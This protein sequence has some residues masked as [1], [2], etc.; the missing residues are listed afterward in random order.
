MLQL[1]LQD[2]VALVF[3]GDNEVGKE[4]IQLFLDAGAKV[5]YLCKSN[6]EVERS[7]ILNFKAESTSYA[8]GPVDFEKNFLKGIR[9]LIEIDIVINNLEADPGKEIMDITPEEWEETMLINLDIPFRL[10][11]M[12]TPFMK[13]QNNGVIIN[14]SSTSAVDGG[15]G[16]VALA[17]SKSALESMCKALSRELGPNNIRVNAVSVGKYSDEMM[18]KVPLGREVTA[19]DI[20]NTVFLLTTPMAS[21]INGQTI[22]LDGG[23]T[24][25]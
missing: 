6:M 10:I 5:L 20:A 9:D 2:K 16:N 22:L 18:E 19:S 7:L 25:A 17:A 8:L 21:Y 12:V 13:K 3:D 24:L 14:I 23:K 1:D 11:K 15:D 4:I